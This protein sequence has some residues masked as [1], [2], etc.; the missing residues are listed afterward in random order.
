MITT[1]P[2]L[3]FLQQ[4]LINHSGI[5][6]NR[7]FDFVLGS[8]SNVNNTRVD[9]W[10]GPTGVYVFPATA[11]QMRVV[12]TSAND[13]AAGTGARTVHIHYLDTNYLEG[14]EVVT[15]NGTT[16]VNTVATNIL[17]I[18][19][20]HV[21][22]A[23]S[24]GSSAGSISLQDTVGGVTYA[25]ILATFNTAQQAIYTVPAGRTG[26]ISHWQVSSGTATGTHFTRFYLRTNSHL[27]SPWSVMLSADSM[28]T[29]NNGNAITFP[30]PIRI[31]EKTDVKLSA[32]SDAAS[33]GAICQ[34]AIMG[35]YE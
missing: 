13:T 34:G 5:Y 1:S 9:L 17:R 4:D 16:P 3:P 15:L 21:T 33:A 24:L 18:N 20:F 32:I 31:P 35:W 2:N 12:S 27:G 19:G 29:Q 30:I 23:G 11:I 22:T 28:G 10:E 26:Y 25:F 7:G 14:V 8:N 6:P